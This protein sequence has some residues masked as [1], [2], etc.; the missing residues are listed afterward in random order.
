VRHEGHTG[1]IDNM[2]AAIE[3]GRADV[4]VDGHQGRRT[5]EI[6][7]AIYKAAMTGARVTLPLD[8]GDP[9]CTRDGLLAAAPRFHEKTVSV[10]GF[11]DNQITVTGAKR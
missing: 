10:A 6:I 11:A 9:F 1:Q 8:D 3:T 4:L 2:L 7:T 5:L